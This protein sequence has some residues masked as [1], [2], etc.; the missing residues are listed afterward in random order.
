MTVS[1]GPSEK[2]VVMNIAP[3]RKT[4]KEHYIR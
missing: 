2:Q 3:Q 1:A 4:K